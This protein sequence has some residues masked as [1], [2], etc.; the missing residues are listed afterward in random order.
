MVHNIIDT[1]RKEL[2]EHLR[3]KGLG[4]K[5]AKEEKSIA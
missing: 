3:R 5:L 4:M 1:R 2:L